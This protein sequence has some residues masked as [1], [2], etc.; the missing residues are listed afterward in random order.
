MENETDVKIDP[1]GSVN[2]PDTSIQF[3]SSATN[4]SDLP[5]E[6]KNFSVQPEPQIQSVQKATNLVSQ[7]EITQQ[8]TSSIGQTEAVPAVKYAGFWIRWVA[9]FIDGIVIGI[10]IFIVAFAIGFSSII[11]SGAED[12]KSTGLNLMIRVVGA[13]IGWTYFILMTNKYQATLGKMAVGIKVISDKSENLSLGQIMLRETVGKFLSI[14][15]LYIGYMMA[16]FTE[17]KQALHDKFAGTLVIYKNPD[18]KAKGW[19][20]AVIIIAIVLFFIAIIGILASIVL[21]SLNSARIKANDTAVKAALTLEVPNMIIYYDEKDS[22]KGY[23][24]RIIFS[25]GVDACSGQPVINISQDGNTMAIFAKSCSDEKKYYC[26]DENVKGETVESN[27]QYARSGASVCD[28]NKA[29]SEKNNEKKQQDHQ[30]NPAVAKEVL[31]PNTFKDDVFG[32]EMK[33]FENW[34]HSKEKKENLTIFVF[35]PDSNDATS[36]VLIEGVNVGEVVTAQDLE[37]FTASVKKELSSTN[38]KIYDEKEFIYNFDDGSTIKGKQFKAEY[39]E[40]DESIKSWFI[41]V[42]SGKNILVWDY[43]SSI[44]QYEKDYPIALETLK[45]W[46]ITK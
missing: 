12:E 36:N 40:K 17:R 31:L 41:A 15:T 8:F 16:G 20:F 13:M 4:S 10:P 33:Y 18:S 28:P 3:P 23:E 11:T 9:N 24:S 46:K 21:V 39:K 1:Q 44:G 7:P 2:P 38:G 42:P 30:N 26:V 14:I 19:V 37:I 6:S 27:E 34:T 5:Q 43:I 45:S 35:G 32:F 22:Y 29:V 25:K